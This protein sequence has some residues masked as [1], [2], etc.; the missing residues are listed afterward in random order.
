MSEWV[1][2]W[3]SDSSGPPSR[4]W[5]SKVS[6][7]LFSLCPFTLCRERTRVPQSLEL[8]DRL[9]DVMS[10]WLLA[11]VRCLPAR[12]PVCLFVSVVCLSLKA[13]SDLMRER[14]GQWSGF[15]G[16]SEVSIY[17]III[18]NIFY[19]IIAIIIIFLWNQRKQLRLRFMSSLTD[20]IPPSTTPPTAQVH[21][22]LRIYFSVLSFSFVLS[23]R[24]P[25]LFRPFCRTR[26]L[27]LFSE[28]TWLTV[29]QIEECVWRESKIVVILDKYQLRR[30]AKKKIINQIINN[31]SFIH[32][33]IGLSLSR[34][35]LPMFWL[36]LLPM[37]AWV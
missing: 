4:A 11:A 3:V 8:T 32:S 17:I 25:W 2:G 14:V 20:A 28:R 37:C 13:S 22:E 7:F 21:S 23:F 27:S 35:D 24:L 18:I 29:R 1:S 5:L 33:F 34:F 30:S 9:C 16:Q 26:C 10:G 19:V 36:F 31:L 12:R 6:F 15:I